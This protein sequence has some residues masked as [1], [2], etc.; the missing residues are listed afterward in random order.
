MLGNLA[1]DGAR[2]KKSRF[3]YTLH[4]LFFRYILGL[5]I[6][7]DLFTLILGRWNEFILHGYKVGIGPMSW[8]KKS[9]I[10]PKFRAFYKLL[11]R[12]TKNFT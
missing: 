11:F 9:F 5:E 6:I 3:Y 4:S 12:A 8:A 2:E 7:L 1:D 10:E